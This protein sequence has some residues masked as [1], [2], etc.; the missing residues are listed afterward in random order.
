MTYVFTQQVTI[1]LPS[2]SN[3]LSLF[4][5]SIAT[6]LPTHSPGV[7]C[8]TTEIGSNTSNIQDAT[9]QILLD[10]MARGNSVLDVGIT[11][12]LSLC[13]ECSVPSTLDAASKHVSGPSQLHRLLT[14]ENIILGKREQEEAN[15]RK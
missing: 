11:T 9:P 15:A 6:S 12:D 7:P 3:P 4:C 1:L 14:S 10:S 2:T 5:S 13:G 8:A